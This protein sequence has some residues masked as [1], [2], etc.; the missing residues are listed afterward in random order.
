MN[1]FEQYDEPDLPVGAYLVDLDVDV[2]SA[3]NCTHDE[4]MQLNRKISDTTPSR[5]I[6]SVVETA[7]TMWG[8]PMVNPEVSIYINRWYSPSGH[9]HVELYI[10]TLGDNWPERLNGP[11]TLNLLISCYMTIGNPEQAMYMVEQI[12]ETKGL[13]PVNP[14]DG[15]SK[16]VYMTDNH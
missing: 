2:I 4:I 11:Q 14:D 8:A 12:R 5:L 13:M 7:R 1:I 15:S 16:Y 9:A 6:D 10:S 3:R